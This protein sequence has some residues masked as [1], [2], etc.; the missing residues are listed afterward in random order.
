MPV[1]L[2]NVPAKGAPLVRERLDGHDLIDPAVD[3]HAVAVHDGNEV[4]QIMVV[5]RHCGLPHHALLHLAVAEHNV[6]HIVLMVQSPRHGHAHA[7]R[8]AVAQRAAADVNAGCLVHIRVPLQNG[9]VLAQGGEM[10]GVEEPPARQRRIQRRAG[11]A[12]GEHKAVAI[13]PPRVLRVDPHDVKVERGDH[14]HRGE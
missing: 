10:L 6:G 14:V 8:K 2:H 3:L 13:L 1:D 5:R 9:V 4:A 12:L 7:D 11:V